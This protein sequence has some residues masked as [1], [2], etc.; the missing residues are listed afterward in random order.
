M[1][2]YD[3]ML[4]DIKSDIYDA[5]YGDFFDKDV[6]L[7]LAEA[8]SKQYHSEGTS[9]LT[10]AEYD[11]LLDRIHSLG[12]D[13]PGV[14]SAPT[15]GK[16]VRLPM[17][18]GSLDKIKPGDKA[19]NTF[20][21]EIPSSFIVS[22]KLDGVSALLVSTKNGTKL[23]TRGDGSV[24]QDITALLKVLPLPGNVPVGYTVR[25]E[26][27]IPK[28]KYPELKAYGANLRNIVSGLVNSKDYNPTVARNVR[29][30]PYQV[31]SPR[32]GTPSEDLARLAEW[33]LHAV[34]HFVLR[35]TDA[36]DF[37][38]KLLSALSS[39]KQNSEYEID[40]LVVSRD[41]VY[42]IPTGKNPDHAVAFK[43]S[44]VQDHADVTV[45]SVEYRASKD[46]YLIPV[47][48]FDPVQLAGVTVR[49]ATGFN[50][51]FIQDNVIG[52]GAVIRVTRS[53]DV[54]PH[55]VSVTVPAAKAA[56]P[57]EEY[58]F[59]DTGVHA[60][61]MDLGSNMDVQCKNIERFFTGISVPNMKKGVIEKL[62]LNGLDSIGRIL[63]ASEA[64][65]L[66]IP[67]FAQ[68]SASALVISVRDCFTRA[69]L[70][71][72]MAASNA[73]GRG[74]AGKKL[75]IILNEIPDWDQMRKSRDAICK[76]DVSEKTLSEIKGISSTTAQAFIQGLDAFATFVSEI[77][78][79]SW[80]QWEAYQSSANKSNTG[81]NDKNING[82]GSK[83][84]DQFLVFTGFRSSDY[85]KLIESNGGTIQER[86]TKDTTMLLYTGK[87]TRKLETA[88]EKNITVLSK[89]EFEKMYVTV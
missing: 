7:L 45:H 68:R 8:A 32:T 33:G 85:E 88:R 53:G 40:G 18:M 39:R 55:I 54:I 11:A 57:T 30:V 87:A 56:M 38:E 70:E 67:G 65:V 76:L 15:R 75:N 63:G 24:G 21:K 35:A 14:G 9:I 83:F 80:K 3:S 79:E 89:E 78:S 64:D 12:L 50:A 60:V 61:L 34:D 82:T 22:E 6:A 26:L 59:T 46:G 62:F 69:P 23:Y 51:K 42:Q 49:K 4:A 84:K 44:T 71:D 19:I 13:I 5:L 31:C 77:P 43:S 48:Y 25:G 66:G 37:E 72:I 52:P 74:M 81:N 58:H 10:D 73:F 17:Y 86:I 29:F 28:R 1:A 20:F 41:I 27:I 2:G 36:T 16:K 47:V